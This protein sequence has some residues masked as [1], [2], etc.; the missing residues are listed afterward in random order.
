MK[1]VTLA[2]EGDEGFKVTR[3]LAQLKV[4]VS[5][6]HSDASFDQL[7]GAIDAGL[8]MYTH[9]GNGCPMQM[10]R[11]ENIVQ[12]VLSLSDSL[13]PM[14]IADGAHVAYYAL[15]NYLKAA[16]FDRTIVVTDAVTPAGLGPGTYRL[17]HWGDITIADD[18]IAR[19]PDKSHL[20]G[21]IMPMPMAARNLVEKVGLAQSQVEQL[22]STN[23]RK[24][25]FG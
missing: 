13:W 15:K 8:S 4:R 17:G 16:G 9:L 24:A 2:P 11:H 18:Y 14:F 19:S 7:R 20:L 5:A 6:G 25:I 23:P 12:R 22:T 10:H 1:L 3:Y 21:S